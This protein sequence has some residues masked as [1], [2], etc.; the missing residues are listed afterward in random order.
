[1]ETATIKPFV[2]SYAAPPGETLEET[3]QALGISRAGLA[4]GIE[5]SAETV[6]LIIGGDAAIS[7]ETA[8]GLERVTGVPAYMWN[9][10][11]SCYRENLGRR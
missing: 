9:V 4:C 6:D 11:E 10:L 7:P 1:M 3:I 2:P 5:L 8:L